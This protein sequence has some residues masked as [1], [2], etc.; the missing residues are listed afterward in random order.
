M[1][2]DAKG[3]LIIISGPSGVG[4]GTLIEIVTE[5]LKARGIT[6]AFS[7]SATTRKRAETEIDGVHYYF[8]SHERFEEMIR[9]GEVAEYNCYSGNYYGTPCKN[10]DTAIENGTPMILDIDINGKKQ[11]LEKYD[12]CVTVF[13]LPPCMEALE[14]RIRGRA[15]S[16]DTEESIKYRLERAAEEITHRDEYKYEVINDDL[17]T[18][19]DELCAIITREEKTN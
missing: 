12:N 18:A 1:K 8:V 13:I 5:K 11:I 7:V 3:L 16:T 17:E 15:R 19:A 14:E 6:T 9:N 2:N 10:I 4:K